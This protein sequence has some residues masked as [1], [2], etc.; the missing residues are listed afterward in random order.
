[1]LAIAK[2]IIERYGGTIRLENRTGGGLV[3]TVV[4]GAV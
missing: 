1:G 2:E 3:Q 4:F